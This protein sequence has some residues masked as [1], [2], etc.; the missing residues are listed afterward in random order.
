MEITFSFGDIKLPRTNREGK[1]KS[2]IAFPE[3]YC[4]IDIETT[5]LSPL[6]DDIIEI[7]AV[8][9]SAGKEVG[10]FQSLV[11]PPDVYDDGT[12]IDKFIESLT[13]ITNEMLANAPKTEEAIRA[14]DEFL[15]DDIIIGYNVG[16]D[17]NFIYD[18]YVSYLDKPFTNDYIDIMRF[19]FFFY[20][21]MDHHRLKD[22]VSLFGISQEQE[23]RSLGDVLATEACYERMH[24]E[25]LNR[26]GNEEPFINA[27]N[28]KAPLVYE[29]FS[30]TKHIST[31][32]NKY[33]E[34]EEKKDE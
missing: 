6:C 31:I 5:G 20:P 11:Q 22:M 9:Y 12:F 13:G 17:V 10:R 7:G 32:K 24:E 15:G 33:K 14:F 25:V 18:C 29:Q 23:H 27:F 34:K 4:V 3:T 8:R 26:Y 28:K 16:F 2:R 1:G 21:E 19:F 30:K